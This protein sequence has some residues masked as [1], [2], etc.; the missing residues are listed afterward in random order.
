ML[1]YQPFF[2]G[3]IEN[4]HDSKTSAFGACF[5][6]IFTLLS[7]VI[8][9]IKDAVTPHEERSSSRRRHEYD[10]LPQGTAGAAVLRDYALSLELPES[11]QD[12]V[13]S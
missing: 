4:V 8:Y 7:S 2:V 1:T 13:F 9:L 10:G 3:G 12:G 11:V 5:F 6:F